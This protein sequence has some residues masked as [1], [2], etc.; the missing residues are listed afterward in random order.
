MNS[1]KIVNNHNT[2]VKSVKHQ[3]IVYTKL[4]ICDTEQKI[5]VCIVR[6]RIGAKN[7][8]SLF[9]F[10]SKLSMP[11]LS[12]TPA[13][14]HILSFFPQSKINL[15]C[16]SRRIV[17]C[18]DTLIKVIH[19]NHLKS[20]DV[21]DSIFFYISTHKAVITFY[22]STCVLHWANHVFTDFDYLLSN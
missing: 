17:T 11:R 12:T 5:V 16:S 8:V 19:V 9:F 18:F 7:R 20:F 13:S 14:W 3:E 6:V 22:C 10:K 1:E 2:P 15:S 4:A 21:Y